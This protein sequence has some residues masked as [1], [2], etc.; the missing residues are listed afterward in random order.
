MN[1]YANVKDVYI[2]THGEWVSFKNVGTVTIPKG[3][4]NCSSITGSI[5]QQRR[6][7]CRY[8]DCIN[9]K[10]YGQ[11]SYCGAPLSE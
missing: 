7:K 4:S 6:A 11:C 8:C 3:Y 1:E 5:H 9:D 10:D 2:K